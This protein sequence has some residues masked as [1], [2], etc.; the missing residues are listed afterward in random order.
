MRLPPLILASQ[1]PQR[2]KLLKKLRIPFQIFPA[3]VSE[4]IAEKNPRRV[5]EK[6]AL[7]KA[8]W[9][10]RRRS[11]GLILGSDTVVAVA[12]K[13]LNK[14]RNRKDSMRMIGLLNGTW[15]RVHTGVA[16]INAASG[17]RWTAVRVSRV[18]ARRL[19]PEALRRLAGKHMDKAGS[20]AMQDSKDPF[21][22]KVVGP[23]DNVIGLPL[24]DVRELLKKAAAALKNH[25][26]P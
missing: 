19:K 12:G 4:K 11:S 14:P 6:L 21:I 10:A 16:L 15:H 5:V 26:K 7:R 13:I 18:K 20:Y 1:S 22:Q 23:V 3:R 17:K 24:R 8:S 25:R 2:R 9:V